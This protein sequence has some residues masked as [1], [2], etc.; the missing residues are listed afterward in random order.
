VEVAKFFVLGFQVVVIGMGQNKV[1]DQEPGA[2]QFV[3]KT[4]AIA[5]IVLVDGRIKGAREEVVDQGMTREPS[6]PDVAMSEGFSGQAGAHTPAIDPG[7]IEE[8][9]LGKVPGMGG[10]EVKEPRF[11]RGITV[12]LDGLDVFGTNA[13]RGECPA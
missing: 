3:G 8:L 13:H 10:D 6:S 5:E 2:D 12:A 9:L 7:K 11:G 4:A 1:Q